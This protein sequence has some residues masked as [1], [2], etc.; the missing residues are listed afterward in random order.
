MRP[1]TA[2]PRRRASINR[3]PRRAAKRLPSLADQAIT[4]GRSGDPMFS[5]SL[6]G[7]FLVD[8]ALLR[9]RP[10]RD[11]AMLRMTYSEMTEVSI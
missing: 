3:S 4:V 10:F 8:L 6:A 5:E 7:R 1:T 11:L 2:S 9:R